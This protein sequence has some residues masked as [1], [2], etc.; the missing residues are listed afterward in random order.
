MLALSSDK[1]LKI[2]TKD[3]ISQTGVVVNF[4]FSE[5]HQARFRTF[6]NGEISVKL[7]QSVSNYDVFV[8]A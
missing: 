2:S 8:A 7:E 3:G 5:S 4:H 1:F 6:A